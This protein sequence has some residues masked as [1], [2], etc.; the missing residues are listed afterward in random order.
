MLRIAIRTLSEASE[1][2]APD[3]DGLATHVPRVGSVLRWTRPR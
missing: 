1:E 2:L 3:R